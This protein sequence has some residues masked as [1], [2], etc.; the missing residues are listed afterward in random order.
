MHGYKNVSPHNHPGVR[1]ENTRRQKEYLWSSR[2]Q[3]ADRADRNKMATDWKSE[4]M[5][6]PPDKKKQIE[7]RHV[8]EYEIRPYSE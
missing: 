4:S 3:S 1:S 7:R 2:Q 5:R 6:L 8:P